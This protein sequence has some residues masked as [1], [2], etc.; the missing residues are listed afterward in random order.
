M[1]L[2]SVPARHWLAVASIIFL[3]LPGSSNLLYLES[4]RSILGGSCTTGNEWLW[5]GS[6]SILLIIPHLHAPRCVPSAKILRPKLSWI[7][8]NVLW[9]LA[10]LVGP[11]LWKD[12]VQRSLV[13]WL[14]LFGGKA[15]WPAMWN[16]AILVFPTTRLSHLLNFYYFDSSDSI[17]TATY[18]VDLH[19]KT[20]LTMAAWLAVH[21][22]L[23]CAAYYIRDIHAPYEFLE[24][25]LPLTHYLSEGI[26]NFSGWVGG[27]SL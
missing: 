6:I 23:L 22:V 7:Q 9:Y 27:V 12:R 18:L 25:M 20:S 11:I 13:D 26:Y 3:L 21:T 15:A 5:I 4:Y 10:S 24:K 1:P 2:Y 16:M 14:E 17:G 8:L 19:T